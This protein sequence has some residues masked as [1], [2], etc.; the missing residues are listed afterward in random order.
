MMFPS[1]YFGFDICNPKLIA[2]KERLSIVPSLQRAFEHSLMVFI[3][4][5]N[6][7]RKN[8]ESQFWPVLQYVTKYAEFKS[9]IHFGWNL[10]KM[11]VFDNFHFRHFYMFAFFAIFSY[12]HTGANLVLIKMATRP[13]GTRGHLERIPGYVG[14][15]GPRPERPWGPEAGPLGRALRPSAWKAA[16]PWGRG[17]LRPGP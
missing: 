7:I 11:W 10:L 17:A 1:T 2:S 14:P 9:A 4:K 6:H 5:R 8:A 3:S 15:L 13:R 12:G 16:G